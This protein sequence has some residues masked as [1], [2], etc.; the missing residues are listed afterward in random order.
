MN[1]ILYYIFDLDNNKEINI[2]NLSKCQNTGYTKMTM[3]SVKSLKIFANKKFLVFSCILF[4]VFA[5]SSI[6]AY[7]ISARQIN[8]SFIKN[9]LSIASETM[10]LRLEAAVDSDLALVLKMADTPVIRQYFINPSDPA[11]KSQA[12]AEIAIYKEHFKNK[13]L[14][15][16]ND[17]DKMFYSTRN[18]PYFVNPDDPKNYWYNL[19]LYETEKYIFNINYNPDLDQ[20][21]LWVNVPVF[22]EVQTGKKPVG[23]VGTGINLTDF[24]NFVA[25]GY[26]KFDTHITTYMFN[27]YNEITSAADYELVRNK[28]RLDEHL[29][30]TGEEL[31]KAAHELSEGDSR[32]FIYDKKIYLLSSIPTMKWYL[33]ISYPTPSLLSLNN[34]MNTVFFSMLF[35]ILFLFIIINV[36]IARSENAIAKQNLQLIEANR[37]AESASKA[38]SDFLAR[39]SHEIR[40]PMNAITGMAELLLRGELSN[41]ARGYAHDIKQAGNNLVSLINDILDLSKI[42]AG[43]LEIVPVNYILSSLINDTVNIIRAK[44]K[45]KPIRFFT[46]IDGNIP[47]SLIGDEVRI[48]QILINLLSN[49]IKYTEK[50]HIG[51]TITID[52]QDDKQ[53]S[54]RIDVADTGKGIKPEHQANLFDEFVRVDKD[55]NIEGTGLGLPIT[56]RLCE[57]MDGKISMES[58]YGKGSVFTVIIPQGIKSKEPFAVV[59]EP[60]KKKVL[61]YESRL[62]YAKSVCWSLENMKVPYSMVTNQNEFAALLYSEEWFY[63]FSGYGLYEKLKPLMEQSNSVFCG[64]KKP[65]LALMIEWG[66]EVSISNAHFVSIPVQSLSIANTLNGKADR[67]NSYKDFGNSGAI[68]HTFPNARLLIVDDIAT[69]L[70]V[71]EGLMAPYNAK[72]DTCLSGAEA[73]ELVKQNKYDIIFMDHMMPEMDG[74][75]ATAIIRAWEKEQQENSSAS[76]TEGETRS[77]NSNLPAQI[78]IIALTA[79]AV[80][81]MKEMFIKNGFNDF[82][83]K[84]IDVSKLDEILDRWIPKEKKTMSEENNFVIPLRQTQGTDGNVLTEPSFSSPEPIALPEPVEGSKMSELLAIPNV[85][86]AKG[87]TMLRGKLDLYKKVL[88]MFCADADERLAQLQKTPD[89]DTLRLFIINVHSLKS[90]SAAIG[91]QDISSQAAGLEIAGKTENMAFIREHLPEFTVQL[92]ELVKNIRAALA[93]P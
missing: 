51:L 36:F 67:Q 12:D 17:E 82:I 48:R 78:T 28:I 72:I 33:T 53:V 90:A 65:R 15:W 40:T 89:T 1:S 57:A 41:E 70:K 38:K 30:V 21:Y 43:K 79:N 35:L 26:Q 61:V 29:G 16:I 3:G 88:Y 83:S 18:E 93:D 34:A 63:V 14:Y 56:R 2:F 24:S 62:N 19:T 77:N 59:E 23:M 64:G 46:N 54:L 86:T 73:I 25:S 91:A 31:I 69:N 8:H 55:H 47:N 11:F 9:Q 68:R 85:D 49:A 7:F 92:T 27:K 52:K 37:K 10:R 84:P 22:A 87:I 13:I 32:N 71:A 5:L 42:E 39:M 6:T 58:E 74:I 20:I 80:V 81:G 45:E 50:G 75:E 76:F 60:E 66:A 4:F 44:L